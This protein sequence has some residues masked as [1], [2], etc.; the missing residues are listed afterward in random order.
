[1]EATVWEAMTN[2]MEVEADVRHAELIIAVLESAD[3]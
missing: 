3:H 1:L 2:V